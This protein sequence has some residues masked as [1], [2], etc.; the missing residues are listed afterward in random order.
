MLPHRIN[1]LNNINFSW[2]PLDTYQE[3]KIYELMEFKKIHGHCN[4]PAKYPENFSLGSWVDHKR[5]MYRKIKLPKELIDRL[6]SIGFNWNPKDSI[7]DERYL[8]L[9]SFKETNGHCDVTAKYTE[10]PKLGKWVS[11]QRSSYRKGELTKERIDKL[12][13][14]GFVWKLHDD[15]WEKMYHALLKFKDKN[16][17]CNVTQ[18]YSENPSLGL[19]VST[20]RSLC[21]KGKLSKERIDKLNDIGFNWNLLDELDVVWE[22]KYHELLLFKDKNC[23][24]GVPQI[25]PDNPGLGI[26]V[27]RQRSMYRKRKLSEERINKLNNI[28]FN[29]NPKSELEHSIWEKR[30]FQLIKFKEV[31][32]HCNVPA[33]YTENP[34]LG[35]W[36]ATQRAI[37]R[38]GKLSEERINKLNSIGFVWKLR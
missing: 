8:E 31:K 6:D 4:V 2:S 12:N 29:W 10:N 22:K 32:A 17:H 13:Q 27:Q 1:K 35:R 19:W 28:G 25:Y 34:E 14:L 37:Y 18:T 24:C 38:K 3:Q 16:G 21:Y 23:H 33:K 36:V 9:I 7:W 5:C 30:Y 20:Q 15:T 11:W 26:W